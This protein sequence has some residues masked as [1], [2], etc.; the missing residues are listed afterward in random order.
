MDSSLIKPTHGTFVKMTLSKLTLPS[1]N[2]KHKCVSSPNNPSDNRST[3]SQN[4]YYGSIVGVEILDI[5]KNPEVSIAEE[6][7][8]LRGL[9]G[10][11][12]KRSVLG[13]YF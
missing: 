13:Y 4:K 5:D 7:V 3:Q 11:K 10:L 2:F 6:L 1:K 8:G 9:V 12:R